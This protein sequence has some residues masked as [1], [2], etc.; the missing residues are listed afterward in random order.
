MSHLLKLHN[1]SHCVLD[2]KFH[3]W[4]GA[5]TKKRPRPYGLWKD[6]LFGHVSWTNPRA[7]P[8]LCQCINLVAYRICELL[9]DVM[10]WVVQFNTGGFQIWPM[11]FGFLWL[12]ITLPQ[13]YYFG[14]R[15]FE[16]EG[17]VQVSFL[18]LLL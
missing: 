1:N 2:S 12:L 3:R 7:R 13:I 17:P 15:G 11:A 18:H 6:D 16:G 5:S 4:M 9:L 8:E 14:L 10:N